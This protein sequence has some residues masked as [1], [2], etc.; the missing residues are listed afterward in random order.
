MSESTLALQMPKFGG[1]KSVNVRSMSIEFFTTMCY[2]ALCVPVQIMATSLGMGVTD[3]ASFYAIVVV[4]LTFAFRRETVAQMNPVASGTFLLT[5]KIN[6]EQCLANIASQLAGG[7]IGAAWVAMWIRDDQDAA[8]TLG[9]TLGYADGF[10][11]GRLLFAEAMSSWLLIITLVTATNSTT[12]K[13]AFFASL[14]IGFSYFIALSLTLGLTGGMINPARSFGTAVAASIRRR[15]RSPALAENDLWYRHWICWVAPLVATGF[16]IVTDFIL[17]K[18]K[19]NDTNEEAPA[20][21]E[22]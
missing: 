14:F 4:L 8:V 6:V 20:W 10:T 16:A 13:N 22:V 1:V 21:C 17:S 19:T 18:I 9:S 5:G 12:K 11:R 7:M 2:V 3:V 15:M